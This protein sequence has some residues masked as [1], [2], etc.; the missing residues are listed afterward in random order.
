M[1]NIQKNLRG[2]FNVFSNSARQLEVPLKWEIESCDCDSKWVAP[3]R[4]ISV[5]PNKVNQCSVF[6]AGCSECIVGTIWQIQDICMALSTFW[7]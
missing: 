2:S 1:K 5:L 4:V 7:Q 6:T 3:N